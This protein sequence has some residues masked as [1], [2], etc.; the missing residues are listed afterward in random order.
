MLSVRTPPGA[1]SVRCVKRTW[2]C[3]SRCS[4]HDSP[5]SEAPAMM[6]CTGRDRQGHTCRWSVFYVRSGHS[7]GKHA[8]V[9]HGTASSSQRT[10]TG[11]QAGT[12]PGSAWLGAMLWLRQALPWHEHC[13]RAGAPLYHAR[14]LLRTRHA[15]PPSNPNPLQ[16]IKLYCC[17]HTP[18][19]CAFTTCL[20]A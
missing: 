1:S 18:L 14:A 16:F 4:R 19:T 10:M 12:V 7:A 8:R 2:G 11:S 5:V 3:S 15:M 9:K 17:A 13:W 6:I 20:G